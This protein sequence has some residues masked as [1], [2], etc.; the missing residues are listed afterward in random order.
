MF[1]RVLFILSAIPAEEFYGVMVVWVSF[2]DGG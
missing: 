2:F 1:G